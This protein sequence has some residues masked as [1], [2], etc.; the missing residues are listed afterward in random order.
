M[1]ILSIDAWS[2]GDDEDEYQSWN[3]NSW[4]NVG[5]ISKEDFELLS[6]CRNNDNDYIKWFFDNG[7]TTSCDGAEIEDDG[8]N[9]V[10]KDEKTGEPL[11]AIEYGNEY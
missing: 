8:Y 2:N 6:T 5:E 7:Y 11:F 1:K 10:V 4:H 9:V 3:W